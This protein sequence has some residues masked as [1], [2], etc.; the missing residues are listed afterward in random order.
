M[1][2]SNTWTEVLSNWWIG[3]IALGVSLVIT[4]I[5]RMVAYRA[6][7]V[8]R[9]DDLLKPHGRPIAYL[10]GVGICAGLLGGLA[11]YVLTDAGM[12]GQW[13]VIGHAVRSGEWS[14]L[15]NNPLWHL[16][17]IALASVIIMAVG[18][19]DDVK[20]IRPGQ[21]VLGQIVAAGVLLIGGVG[22]R[23][24]DVF[25]TL[26]PLQ[27][28]VWL[29]AAISGLM[30]LFMVICTCNATNLL[31]GLDG[32][33]SGVTGIIALGFLALAVHLAMYARF[34]SVDSL[35][36]GLCLAMVGAVLGFLP[37]NIPPA[38]IF[39]GDAGSMLLGFFVA[40]MMAL[41]CQ[42]GTARWLAAAMVVFALPIL[43]TALAVVRRL[44]SRQSIFAGDRG[45]LYDQLVDRG[46]TVRQ[47]VALFYALA[48]LAAAVGVLAAFFMQ[49][50]WAMVLYTLLL[51]IVWGVF[52]YLGM[53]TPPPRHASGQMASGAAR[54]SPARKNDD[55]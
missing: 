24:A 31:D 52:I 49:L 44:L 15:V 32:L 11:A 43:D 10:G 12:A 4:P 3:A 42:E 55:A 1:I 6:K 33:A 19:W 25:L 27:L 30:C 50:R 16:I 54:H 9:P 51:A 21:K 2:P 28:P 7:L 36:V 40:T 13:R 53:V 17:H 20:G 48:A 29:V 46:M 39:M 45:H 26:I 18:L 22:A 34:A 5:V 38:S 23:M 14:L 37:Y 41:F 35:R 47:V 8:D